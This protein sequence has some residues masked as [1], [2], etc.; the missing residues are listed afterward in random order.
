MIKLIVGLGNVGN[1]YAQT[2]HNAGFWLVEAIAERHHI[3]L[4]HDKKF[5]GMVGRGTIGNQEIRLLMPDTLMNRSGQ[6][7]APM[8]KF[9]D[10]NPDELLVAHDE[11]DIGAGLVK[12]KTGGGHGGH[13]GLRDIMPHTGAQFHRLRIGIGRPTQGDVSSFV[14][15]KPSIDDRISIDKAIECVLDNLPLLLSGEIDKARSYINAFKV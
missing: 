4:T 9:F 15:S 6:A 14:L 10:I 2:R 7:V 11:L 1:A 3:S 5:H 8:V 13:N 12:L